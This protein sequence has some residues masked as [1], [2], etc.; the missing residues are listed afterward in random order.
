MG[1]LKDMSNDQINLASETARETIANLIIAAIRSREGNGWF[2]NLNPTKKQEEEERAKWV[3][4]FCGKNTYDVDFDYI[5]SEYNHLGC[6]LEVEME[7]EKNNNYVYSGDMKK[8]RG[9]IKV[10]K[11]KRKKWYEDAGDGHMIPVEKMR[12][13]HDIDA[14]IQAESPHNDG[15]TRKYYQDLLSEEIVSEN[16]LGYIYES[17]DGGETIYR[18]KVGE[19]KREK[20][21]KKDWEQ[22]NRNRK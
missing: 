18:R 6:E 11:K 10:K 5:G 7:E 17:P 3:C 8:D 20:V 9:T 15:Y 4:S 13:I 19:D 1:V 22:Y 12:T 21:S 16:S 14:K 2:L